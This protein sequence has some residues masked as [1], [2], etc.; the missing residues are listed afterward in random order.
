MDQSDSSAPSQSPGQGAG[1]LGLLLA[2]AVVAI[3]VALVPSTS[4][5]AQKSPVWLVVGAGLAVF[6]FLPL[7]WHGLAE[8]RGSVRAAAP[9]TGRTRFALRSLAVAL[10]V[11]GVSVGNLGPTRVLQNVRRLADRV[12]GQPAVKPKPVPVRPPVVPFGLEPFIPA[13][14]TLAVGL[15]GSA[16]MEQLLGTHGVDTREKLAALATCKIDFAKARVLIAARGNAAYM[17]VVR[18]PGLSEERN[19]YCLVG[20]MGSDRIALRSDQAGGAKTLQVKGL[21]SRPLTFRLLDQTTLIA[22]DESWQ[23]TAA[24]KLFADDAA[25]APGLL[26]LPLSRLDRGAPLWVASAEETAQG[27]WDLAIDSREE[28]SMFNLQ[29]SAT[30]PSGEKDRAQISVRVPLAFASALPER[31]VALGIRGIVTAV[32]ATSAVPPPTQTAPVPSSVEDANG[33]AAR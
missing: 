20:V 8:A 10:V 33:R 24:A 2:S 5:L 1:P 18:A 7:L 9:F 13:D 3:I 6:P 16:A 29:G 21:L 12:R 26:A 22:I 15:A 17:V 11:L 28:G 32:V 31:A 4:L 25:V 27:T 30:P 23:D 19:L 14:A